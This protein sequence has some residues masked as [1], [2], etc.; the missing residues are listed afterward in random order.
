[1]KFK[2]AEINKRYA[3]PRRFYHK[4]IYTN[5]AEVVDLHDQK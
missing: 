5:E 4:E 3:F 1:M 2:K